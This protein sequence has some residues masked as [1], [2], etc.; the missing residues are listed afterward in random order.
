M[1]QRLIFNLAA[2]TP[3][4]AGGVANV[5][6]TFVTRLPEFAPQ[7]EVWALTGPGDWGHRYPLYGRAR[8]LSVEGMNSIK[9]GRAVELSA[10]P[11]TPRAERWLRSGRRRW[12]RSRSYRFPAEWSKHTVVHCPYQCV[13]PLPPHAWNLPYV[14][15]LHDIQHEHFPEFFSP[16]QLKWRR[17]M[18]FASA[19]HAAAVCVVDEWTKRDVLAHLPIPESK[20]FVA[21]IGPTWRD[22]TL[23]TAATKAD[24]RATYCIPDAFAFY[25]AQTWPHKN[26][27]RLLE[28]IAHLK[29][30]TGVAVNLVCTGHLTDLHSRLAARATALGVG[31]QIRFLG[32][33]PD[34]HVTALYAMARLVVVPTLFEGGAGMVVL[35]ALTMGLPLAASTACGI[36]DAVGEAGLYFDPTSVRQMAAAITSLWENEALRQDLGARALVRG[37]AWRWEHIAAGYMEVYREVLHRKTSQT[38]A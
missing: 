7:T 10:E 15:N 30:E 18:Y 28:A 37:R 29:S 19:T 3:E 26:H 20:V 8:L 24:I 1:L 4:I 11:S 9:A 22:A 33:L 2:V 31:S 34:A 12:T 23:V 16:D 5:C 32:L 21:P 13:H 6:Q 38:A 17:E 14:I 25:P 35:E 27:E 36:R